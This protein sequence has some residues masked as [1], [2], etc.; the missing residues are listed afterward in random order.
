MNLPKPSCRLG[1]LEVDFALGS[2]VGMFRRECSRGQHLWKE[3]RESR[4][5]NGDCKAPKTSADPMGSPGAGVTFRVIASW[6]EGDRL[7]STP[8]RPQP[9][10]SPRAGFW[11]G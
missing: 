3:R 7:F 2:S 1:S 5:G 8:T 11:R 10:L 6:D 4:I 9:W